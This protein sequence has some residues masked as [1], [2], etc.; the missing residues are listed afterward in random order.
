MPAGKAAAAPP[1]RTAA[2]N[3][4][5][6]GGDAAAEAAAELGAKLGPLK[7]RALGSENLAVVLLPEVRSTAGE[8]LEW[9]ANALP[10][11]RTSGGA[12]GGIAAL[13]GG[14]AAGTTAVV[15]PESALRAVPP[16]DGATVDQ[17]WVAL[18]ATEPD[19]ATRAPLTA[20][21]V[22]ALGASLS[23]ANVRW[24]ALPSA[25]ANSIV[26]VHQDDLPAATVALTR[27]GH[28]VSPPTRVC[29][30]APAEAE[31]PLDK[32]SQHVGVWSLLRREET[33]GKTVEEHTAGKGPIR[34]QA[35]SGLYAEIRIPA[36]ADEVATQESCG[37]YH[38]VV[39]ATGG[40]RM[41]VRYRTVD[42]RPPNGCV[43]CT[44]VK[45][46]RE[47][48]GE[49]S[50]PRGRMRD[51]YIEAWTRLDSGPMVALELTSE[52]NP[53]NLPP[54][55]WSR[56]GYWLFCGDR[57]ARIVAPRRGQGIVAGAC[58]SSISQLE[59]ICGSDS[60]R[61][62]LH[63]A[64]EACWGHLE[65]PGVLRVSREAWYP[66][67]TGQVLY[68][69]VAGVGG[70]I[71]FAQHEVIHHL[72]NGL[73]QRWR[74]RD[75]GFDPFSVTM[76]PAPAVPAAQRDSG[77]ASGSS[78]EASSRSG[79]RARSSSASS[80]GKSKAAAA[81][82][83]PAP[84]TTGKAKANKGGSGSASSRSR[85]SSSSSVSMAKSSVDSGSRS[86]SRGKDRRGKKDKKSK[87][88]D[89][90]ASDKKRGHDRDRSRHRRRKHH[91]RRRR[92]EDEPQS[93]AVAPRP[94][95]PPVGYPPM[96]GPY[97]PQVYAPYG[98]RPDVGVP[99]R[100]P[101]GPEGMPPMGFPGA[102]PP[103]MG[104]PPHGHHGPPPGYHAAPPP[105]GFPHGMHPPGFPPAGP[106]GLPRHR[107]PPPGAWGAPPRPGM[108]PGMPMGGPPPPGGPPP[109][110]PM[111]ARPPPMQP[112]PPAVRPAST[113][114]PPGLLQD[115][116]EQLAASAAEADNKSK[117]EQ[118]GGSGA[119]KE[120]RPPTD[121]GAAKGLVFGAKML[122]RAPGP[123]PA[124]VP[125]PVA[126]VPAANTGEPQPPESSAALAGPPGALG[127]PVAPEER[128]SA[129]GQDAPPPAAS[130][131]PAVPASSPPPGDDQ[132]A[133]G[134]AAP[135]PAA[136]AAPAANKVGSAWGEPV[137]VG[138][139]WGEPVKRLE[140]TPAP[141]P[142]AQP[143]AM[144]PP[145]TQPPSMSPPAG[146]PPAMQP[147]SGAPPG[148]LAGTA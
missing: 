4:R 8:A 33:V 144:Q 49:L 72:P 28:A 111:Q 20:A 145:S 61:Q 82:A 60:V 31:I 66:N 2:G 5:S 32:N 125:A 65:R 107:P 68:D 139:G 96:V 40:R 137:G 120:P 22:G 38:A 143:P 15:V 37:G 83:P 14:S 11:A 13:A 133:G 102:G 59:A 26:L 87:R 48:M 1:Q 30:P 129:A 132:G 64:Y 35:P 81:P 88:K 47:V 21:A 78:D 92:R 104:M 46:D 45:F 98:P 12:D 63:S 122:V 76:N 74:I 95:A 80:R 62:E 93:G 103:H 86:R 119:S 105:H 56:T 43:L 126:P 53:P 148:D 114:P 110:Q 24:R 112:M 50:H 97:P 130:P 84:A 41:S 51:E 17:I 75:W 89:E 138:S 140:E 99:P 27:N 94:A 79:S 146:P 73:M 135:A 9:L 55:P 67:R 141:E 10:K 128:S 71:S 142:A 118:S 58:C 54:L 77:S 29:P 6:H 131:P 115:R 123:T 52:V 147:P 85:S 117:R 3:G 19:S 18:E 25:Q 39:D 42:F 100:R 16:P 113:S 23:A 44:Q 116:P 69:A 124:P 106:Y 70:T 34:M 127:E 90:K 134:A 7:L 136:P 108:P 101:P 91:R 109:Q 57:F 36:Q 121:A